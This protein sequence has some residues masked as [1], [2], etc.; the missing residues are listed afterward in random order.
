M[1]VDHEREPLDDVQES[2]VQ[3][4]G[5]LVNPLGNAAYVICGL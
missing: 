5:E 4:L 1:A 3:D 2:N